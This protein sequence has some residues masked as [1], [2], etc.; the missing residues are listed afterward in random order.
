MSKH[1]THSATPWDYDD[2]D[3]SIYELETSNLITGPLDRIND[4]QANAAHI[5]LC[6]NSHAALVEALEDAMEKLNH[7]MRHLHYSAETTN[8]VI[9][10]Y[11]AALAL[12]KGDV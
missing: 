11:R 12:A 6:V 3:F 10:P 7:T 1:R 9:T 2:G 5:V 8:A 4:G